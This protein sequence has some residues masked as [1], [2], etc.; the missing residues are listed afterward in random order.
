MLSGISPP[1]NHPSNRYAPAK[2]P[3]TKQPHKNPNEIYQFTNSQTENKPTTAK[4]LSDEVKTWDFNV[5]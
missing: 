1:L 5:L 4:L 3:R 2:N